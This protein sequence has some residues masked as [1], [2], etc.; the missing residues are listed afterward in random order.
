MPGMF[1]D[2][3][4]MT[5]MHGLGWLV[6]LVLLVLL[7]GIF[8]FG[9]GR[10]PDRGDDRRETPLEA[11]RRRLANGDITVAEYEERKAL[12]DRDGGRSA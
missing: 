3:G 12:L 11:L 8:L 10:Y 6:L 7:A 1:Y 9:R 5:G 4:Y 2:G